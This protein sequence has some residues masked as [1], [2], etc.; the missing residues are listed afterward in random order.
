MPSKE[1]HRPQGPHVAEP[2]EELGAVRGIPRHAAGLDER[3]LGLAVAQPAQRC[4]GLEHD[5]AENRL[6]PEESLGRGRASL[7]EE[8]GAPA[9]SASTPSAVTRSGA[10]QPVM[11]SASAAAAPGAA[12][13]ATISRVEGPPPASSSMQLAELVPGSLVLQVLRELPAGLE[14]RQGAAALLGARVCGR[15]DEEAAPMAASQR[16]APQHETLGRAS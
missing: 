11:R 16:P 3:C 4:L 7:A 5:G 2:G 8:E 14:R 12:F 9:S 13:A 6:T 1:E 15:E 10:A